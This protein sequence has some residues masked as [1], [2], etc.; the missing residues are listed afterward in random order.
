MMHDTCH[1]IHDMP[2]WSRRKE[3][4]APSEIRFAL[5]LRRGV[6]VRAS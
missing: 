2:P 4:R 1:Y 5:D 3:S 6:G